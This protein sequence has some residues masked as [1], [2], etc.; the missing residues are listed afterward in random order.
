MKVRKVNDKYYSPGGAIYNVEGE[1]VGWLSPYSSEN[2]WSREFVGEYEEIEPAPWEAAP[3]PVPPE[4]PE[5]TADF[6][7]E[8]GYT[9][10]E[11]EKI[12]AWVRENKMTPSPENI[13]EIIAEGT[14][15]SFLKKSFDAAL[16]L[17]R[18]SSKLVI[19]SLLV[20]LLKV[21]GG[22]ALLEDF[23]RWLGNKFVE[24]YPEYKVLKG[25]P[26]RSISILAL[27]G[28]IGGILSFGVVVNWL[29]KEL[30]E[31]SGIAVWAAIEAED[32]EVANKAN[33]KYR[34]FI[35]AANGWYASVLGWLNPFVK[36]F[37]DKNRDSQIASYETYQE[38]INKN[39][40]DK[41]TLEVAANVD[42]CKVWI[43]GTFRGRTPLTLELK[44]GSYTVSVTKDG[45]NPY[46]ETVEI[47]KDETITV[48]AVLTLVKEVGQ[49]V[50]ISDPEKGA[51][52]YLDGIPQ[53]KKTDMTIYDVPLGLH[54]IRIY[55]EPF[56]K[57]EYVS[58]PEEIEVNLTEAGQTARAEFKLEA[59]EIVEKPT[60]PPTVPEEK[61]TLI[62]DVFP[63]DVDVYLKGEKKYHIDTTGH[64]EIDLDAGVYDFVLR[65]EG[66]KDQSITAYIKSGETYYISVT[67]TEI[68]PTDGTVRILTNVPF[69]DVKRAYILLGTTDSEGKLEIT[70][71]A[72]SHMLVFV[73]EG[74]GTEIKTAI[75]RAGEVTELT[76]EML[77]TPPVAPPIEYNAWAYTIISRPS[78]A[79][80]I[81]DDVFTGKWTTDTIY[82][83]PEAVYS[84]RLEK[85]GYY[86]YE[87][88]IET[89]PL[90]TTAGSSPKSQ[91]LSSSHSSSNPG[92]N[93]EK[94]PYEKELNHDMNF[95]S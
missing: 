81:I 79:K 80:I 47:R 18:K 17:L 52:V 13:E 70:L 44:T 7:I 69:V 57:I 85:A 54:T 36:V 95:Y 68:T 42:D 35:D 64:I 31:P 5:E 34:E 3:P 51:T 27:I 93:K 65:K 21:S 88:T 94:L 61:G 37:F 14:F 38:L 50:V 87:M 15:F 58:E 19:N 75:V 76:V 77:E 22:E 90:P 82:L 20:G 60:P 28:L 78:G 43:D 2:P 26:E 62:L 11:A 67:L 71:P 46:D 12:A 33:Q 41:G 24:E 4:L 59:K 83:E 48:N 66:Y 9:R 91:S 73:K 49:I 55:K 74:Y 84:L 16:A 39:L 1:R 63:G 32:W 53:I 89:E 72:G 29:R 40:V 92:S 6:W 45:Y 86:P 10:E 8:K 30:P 25:A 56:G 23:A